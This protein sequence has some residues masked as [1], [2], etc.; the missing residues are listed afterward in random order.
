VF[1]PPAVTV[2]GILKKRKG[3][4]LEDRKKRDYASSVLV[5]EWKIS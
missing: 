2:F 4:F 3:L 1:L 5:S